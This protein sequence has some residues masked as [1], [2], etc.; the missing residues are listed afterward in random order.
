MLLPRKYIISTLFYEATR[1]LKPKL[2]LMLITQL[3]ANAHMRARTHTH[4]HTHTSSKEAKKRIT[5]SSLEMH[6][7]FKLLIHLSSQQIKG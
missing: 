3:W 2:D 1:V 5:D 4:T 6:R 7:W